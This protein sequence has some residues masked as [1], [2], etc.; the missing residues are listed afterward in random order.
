MVYPYHE[1]ISAFLLANTSYYTGNDAYLLMGKIIAR[2]HSAM[3]NRS[4]YELLEKIKSGEDPRT[5]N[6]I[7]TIFNDLKKKES[8]DN[9]RSILLI[10][11]NNEVVENTIY[12]NII[13]NLDK[14]VIGS[15]LDI[16]MAKKDSCIKK[17]Y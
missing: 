13:I 11:K 5:I 10:L 6:R 4:P 7:F 16:F 9:I 12:D 8:M 14:G 3:H 15:L 17:P 2:H 1:Y